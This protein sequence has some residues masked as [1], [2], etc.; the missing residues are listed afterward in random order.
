MP[1]ER[2]HRG[3]HPEDDRLFAPDQ[4]PS[5]RAAVADLSWLLSRDYSPPSALKIVGD[6]YS[7]EQRQRIAVARCA[8]S[9]QARET[10]QGRRVEI[11]A[12]CGQK[13]AIDGFNVLT[14]IEAALAHGVL[15][16][17]RDGCIRDMASVHGTY[18]KVQETLPAVDLIVKSLAQW[19]PAHCIW[20][21]DAPVSNSGRLAAILRTAAEHAGLAWQVELVNSPDRILSETDAI[22]ATADSVI[23]DRCGAWI[24][25]TSHVL[26]EHSILGQ[27][28]NLS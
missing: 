11:I 19:Q 5:L 24:N 1:D 25:F 23:L 13:L 16:L 14:T 2:Q 26:A 4:W 22:A 9:D 10:R 18:R 20:Y 8:C 7:L 3:R 12:I 21:L 15:L 27:V 17:A 28:C 6:R